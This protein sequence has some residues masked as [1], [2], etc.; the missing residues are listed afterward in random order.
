[1]RVAY[2]TTGK[3]QFLDNKG[4]TLEKWKKSRQKSRR[5]GVGVW[6]TCKFWCVFVRIVPGGRNKWQWRR[7][8]Y[9]GHIDGRWIVL[10][11]EWTHLL[12]TAAFFCRFIERIATLT[13]C[14]LCETKPYPMV[15]GPG[16]RSDG[17]NRAHCIHITISHR[18]GI[19][20]S[21]PPTFG[22]NWGACAAKN[23]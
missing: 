9:W 3:K 23:K 14:S 18:V 17:K 16:K 21:L 19:C 1:M 8:K 12:K 7:W 10:R 20:G 22:Q 13:S 4:R 6:K 2:K 11:I 15:I 5:G